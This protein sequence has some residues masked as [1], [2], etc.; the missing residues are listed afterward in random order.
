MAAKK[1]ALMVGTKKGGYIFRG[2]DGRA[3][4]DVE[5][6]LFAGAPVYHMAFDRRDGRSM[7]AAINSSWGGP[8]I[9]RSTDLGKTWKAVGNPVFREDMGMVLK[10]TWHIEPGHADD[11]DVVW[12]GTEPAA[13]F[14]TR[15]GGEYWETLD[16]LNRHP[17]RDRWEPGGGGLGH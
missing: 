12:A 10:R 17:T 9:E 15:D 4:W 7:W 16:G 1:V 13:L 2:G 6:P 14:R 11:P 3:S 5:G 8:R